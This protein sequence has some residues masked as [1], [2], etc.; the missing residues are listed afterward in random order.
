MKRKPTRVCTV[1]RR[2][3]RFVVLNG[4]RCIGS[5]PIA[6]DE[7]AAE[8]RAYKL[9]EDFVTGRITEHASL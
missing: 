3:D 4:T 9:A 5:E 2:N 6:G 1:E 8:S 7:G